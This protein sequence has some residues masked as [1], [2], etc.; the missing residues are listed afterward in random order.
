MDWDDLKNPFEKYMLSESFPCIRDM[1]FII[2]NINTPSQMEK[3]MFLSTFFNTNPI[4]LFT[5][6]CRLK[7]FE[8][9]ENLVK[10]YKDVIIT[11]DN[12]EILRQMYLEDVCEYLKQN[13]QFCSE[14][15]SICKKYQKDVLDLNRECLVF[16]MT[17]VSVIN[18]IE[19]HF[20]NYKIPYAIVN[21][22]IIDDI[23]F[24]KCFQKIFE[25][26]VLF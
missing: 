12:S 20:C 23:F 16:S 17:F 25:V 26:L 3:F 18:K 9:V 22:N 4:I 24:T 8:L 14:L 6:A 11:E 19:M 7:K 15:I 5:D 21:Y 10:I 2:T 1:S 13:K